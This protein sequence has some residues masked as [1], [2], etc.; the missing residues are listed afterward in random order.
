[1]PAKINM[2][3]TNGNIPFNKYK[4][5]NSNTEKNNLVT[6]SATTNRNKNYSSAL[7][8]SMILRI[9]GVRPG[10]GSCGKH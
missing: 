2:V 9:H 3:I 8:S 7:N 5:I 6:I 10:C 4:N 1:M